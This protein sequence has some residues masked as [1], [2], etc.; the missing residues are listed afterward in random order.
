M[1]IEW[2]VYEGVLVLVLSAL[3]KV[4]CVLKHYLI[5]QYTYD[6]WCKSFLL[7]EVVTKKLCREEERTVLYRK[8]GHCSQMFLQGQLQTIELGRD[9]IAL[10]YHNR[11]QYFVWKCWQENSS[12][13]NGS[14]RDQP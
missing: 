9:S 4:V 2:K 12:R 7:H 11:R 3:E 14:P 6:L 10:E 5:A 13:W 1:G 8:K